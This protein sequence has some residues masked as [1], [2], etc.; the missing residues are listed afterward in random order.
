M[1]WNDGYHETTLC[2][3]NNI[4]Q[5][6][7]GTHLAG[8]RG[9]LTRVVNNYMQSSGI[10]E[11]GKG[12]HHRRRRARRLDLRALGES[13]RPEILLADQGK[14]WFPRKCAPSSKT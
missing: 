3:T 9:A 10:V 2:F 11:E 12:R 4:P 6:D 1:Q 7:G 14:S 5:K 13:A 8:F